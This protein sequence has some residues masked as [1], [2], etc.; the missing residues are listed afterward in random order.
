MQSHKRPSPFFTT[1]FALLAS[2]LMILAALAGGC[3]TSPDKHPYDMGDNG[4][5]INVEM[6]KPI[7]L[8]L[9]SNL[10]AGGKWELTQLDRSVVDLYGQPRTEGNVV[11][12]GLARI[13][14]TMY[15]FRGVGEGTTKI[16]LRLANPD[17]GEVLDTFEMTVVVKGGKPSRRPT[18]PPPGAEGAGRGRE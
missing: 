5:T 8:R 1:R 15:E 7:F 3:G 6:G 12:G 17:T 4:S 18:P 16:A 10:K 9:L 13:Y 2:A 11:V 14:S